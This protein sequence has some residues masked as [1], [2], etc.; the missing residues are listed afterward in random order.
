MTNLVQ[1][2]ISPFK[3]LRLIRPNFGYDQH[4][5]QSLLLQESIFS[6]HALIF[7]LME[8]FDTVTR[9]IRDFLGTGL[10]QRNITEF[11]AP[12]SN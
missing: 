5:L 3:I 8:E 12:K 6:R 1:S 4:S 9:E 7:T 11:F 2:G 10:G